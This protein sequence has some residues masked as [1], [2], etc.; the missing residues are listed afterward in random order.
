MQARRSSNDN[1]REPRLPVACR[2][3]AR[4]ALSVEVLDASRS[5]CRVRIAMPLPV[6]AT[7]KIAL[8]GGTERHARIAWVQDDIFGCEFMAPLGKPDL[9][10]LVVA[11]PV[12][13][14]CS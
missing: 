2:A 9:A 11:T 13:L 14:P 4:I 7:L 6:G 12:A 8:P 10:S 5:G 1:R 3:T